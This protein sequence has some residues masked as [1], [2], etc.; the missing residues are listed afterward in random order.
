MSIAISAERI[1]PVLAW[2]A[3]HK[4]TA[5][6]DLQR[7]CRQPSIS[8]QGLGMREM[9]SVVA[10]S[11]R[12]MEAETSLVP[13]QGFPVVV[14][15][16][17]GESTRR[18]AIYDHY[19]VQPSE[20]LEAWSVP[21]FEAVIKDGRLYARGVADNKGNL[22]A[23]LWAV[24]A[25]RAVHGTLPCGVTFL[26]EGEEEI[27]SP[28]LGD[29]AHAHQELLQ[30]DACLWEAGTRNEQGSITITAGLKGILS[31]ELRIQTV[32]Y[33]LHS[34]N[35]PLA[36]NA[37]WRLVE[38]LGS[39]HE[40]SGKVR[41]PGFYD[42]VRPPTEN[43]RN[44]MARFPTDAE[45]LRQSWK[46]DHLLGGDTDPVTLTE[47]LLYSPTCNICGIWGGYQGPGG[48]TVLPAK[49]GA[50]LDFRLVPDQDPETILALLRHHL[51]EQGFADVEVISLEASS[52]P[53]QS[54][55]ETPL[56]DTLA[57]SA[58]YVYGI[59]PRIL[60]RRPGSGPMEELC[61]RYGLPVVNGAGVGYDGSRVHGPDEHI[62][63]DDFLLNIKLIAV[64]LAE[65]AA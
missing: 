4:D 27:G 48:K 63:L 50:K 5:I 38:V 56:V 31:V 52:R 1:E 45:F 25:W 32:A 34:S 6:A 28:S 17:T 36:P 59:E 24:K 42:A 61:L 53:A 15:R 2:I 49:A 11:L 8:A 12:G 55:M 14:G 43:E 23:R 35:A 47:R 65:F 46:V 58:H 44:L 51:D 16:L 33:D 64:L 30:A 54:S 18:L 19:D 39:L 37:A 29:F 13:T 9:A 60:P 57:R 22:V 7:F 40:S 10:E 41:I 3:E 21:P 20:P 26:V 62:R